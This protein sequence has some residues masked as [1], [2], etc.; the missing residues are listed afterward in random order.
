VRTESL[1]YCRGLQ[2]TAIPEELYDLAA[3]P[4]ETTNLAPDD[5]RVGP[6]R[7]LLEDLTGE[8]TQRDFEAS[9]SAED[10]ETVRVRLRNLG[11]ID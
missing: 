3:D 5:P 7:T 11:Y 1:K 4:E 2:D 10:R 9:L 6:M 8:V